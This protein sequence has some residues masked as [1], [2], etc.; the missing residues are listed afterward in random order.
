MEIYLEILLIGIMRKVGMVKQ[1][2][3]G[4][5]YL[6]STVKVISFLMRLDMNCLGISV[7]YFP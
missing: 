3:P 4:I 7:P 5:E 1:R 6:I 2:K